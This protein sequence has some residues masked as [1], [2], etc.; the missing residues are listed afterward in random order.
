MWKSL[1][2]EG[3]ADLRRIEIVGVEAGGLSGVSTLREL[4]ANLDCV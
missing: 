3:F 1:I 4:E 2:C